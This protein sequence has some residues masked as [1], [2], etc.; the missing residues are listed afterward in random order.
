MDYLYKQEC[1][2]LNINTASTSAVLNSFSAPA[3]QQKK[4]VKH[5]PKIVSRFK[6]PKAILPHIFKKIITNTKKD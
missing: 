3:N 4:V 1:E 2:N 5:V 6:K